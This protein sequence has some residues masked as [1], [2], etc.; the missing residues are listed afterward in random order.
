MY[1]VYVHM[2]I[3]HFYLEGMRN[4]LEYDH[5]ATLVSQFYVFSQ[6]D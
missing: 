4:L 3:S 6:K 2:H 1:G 5:V